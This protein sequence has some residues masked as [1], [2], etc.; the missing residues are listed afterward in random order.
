[1][2]FAVGYSR[3]NSSRDRLPLLM[4][5]VCTHLERPSSRVQVRDPK[6]RER[7]SDRP[8][9][10]SAACDERLDDFARTRQTLLIPLNGTV[11][12]QVAPTCDDPEVQL[13]QPPITTGSRVNV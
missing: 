2:A 4:P 12:Q 6:K 11:N 3:G 7:N 13:L 9:A 10:P 5:F 8:T 1:M